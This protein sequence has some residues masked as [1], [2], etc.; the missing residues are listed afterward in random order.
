MLISVI[1]QK[2][3]SQKK[4]LAYPEPEAA[5]DVVKVGDKIN[6][7]V[8][9]LGGENGLILSKTRA[10]RLVAWEKVEKV[11]EEKQII[12]V[13]ILQVV[14][15]GLLTTAFGL[16]GFIPA[17]QIALHFVKD[18]NEFVGQKVEVEIMEADPKNNASFFLV[19]A[20]LKHN[21]NKNVKKL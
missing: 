5:T 12:E 6:V 9:A 1:K 17:S 7:Y 18:L 4:E 19:V 8:V 16:R 20:F 14:K 11:K 3:L 10:D 2:F 21:V 13:E 15:G